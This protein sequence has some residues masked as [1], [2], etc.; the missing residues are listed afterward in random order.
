MWMDRLQ[1]LPMQIFSIPIIRILI[2]VIVLEMQSMKILLRKKVTETLTFIIGFT[3]QDVDI[4][5][6]WVVD[7]VLPHYKIPVLDVYDVSILILMDIGAIMEYL[8]QV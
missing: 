4:E 7:K 8:F 5:L 3:A 2:V 6:I 1:A